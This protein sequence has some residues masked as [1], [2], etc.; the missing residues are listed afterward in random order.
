MSTWSLNF[1]KVKTD[2]MSLIKLKL[3]ICKY[4]RNIWLISLIL[5]CILQSSS[6]DFNRI[7]WDIFCYFR[8]SLS[9]MHVSKS[10]S[11]D[12]WYPGRQVKLDKVAGLVGFLQILPALDSIQSATRWA[13]SRAFN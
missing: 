1:V 5:G 2:L 13:I 4:K 8:G 11:I 12:M 10:T 3:V 9:P 7:R 6:E